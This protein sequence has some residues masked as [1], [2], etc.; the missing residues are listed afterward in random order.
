LQANLQG[1]EAAVISSTMMRFQANLHGLDVP[2]G[3]LAQLLGVSPST[4]SSALRG[5]AYLGAEREAEALV[6]TIQ[7]QAWQDALHPLRLPRDWEEL[8]ALLNSPFTT[9]EAGELV[10]RIFSK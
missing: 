9:A 6:Y 4:M 8:R 10:S 1:E 7:L 3:A 5:T 2:A